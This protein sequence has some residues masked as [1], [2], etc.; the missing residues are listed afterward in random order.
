MRG[1]NSTTRFLLF[2]KLEGENR[3]ANLFPKEYLNSLKSKIML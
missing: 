2:L 3:L 1:V